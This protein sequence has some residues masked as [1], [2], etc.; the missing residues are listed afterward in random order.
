MPS[1]QPVQQSYTTLTQVNDRLQAIGLRT[2]PTT[3]EAAAKL[4]GPVSR[5]K[6][7]DLL[8]KAG[9]DAAARHW[10]SNRLIE[11]L[12]PES[13]GDIADD[14]LPQVGQ[15]MAPPGTAHAAAAPPAPAPPP[16][17]EPT[18]RP[19]GRGASVTPLH[20]RRPPG[21]ESDG[22]EGRADQPDGASREREYD[23]HV[24]YGAK[25]AVQF[26]CLPTK[27]DAQGKSKYLTVLV[28]AANARGASCKQG[29]DWEDSLMIN[30]E[31]HELGVILSVLMGYEGVA[32]FPGHGPQNDKIFDLSENTDPKWQGGFSIKLQ[33]GDRKF[34][35]PL[36]GTDFLQT[37]G[38]VERAAKSCLG[39]ASILTETKL[40]RLAQLRKLA[41]TRQRD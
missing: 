12:G 13:H 36:S 39:I 24:V 16:P 3:A 26:Q 30:M 7:V 33:Q 40:K 20:A 32:R 17:A 11:V 29:I 23:E 4:R 37:L 1:A 27:P 31:P 5:E 15:A 34:Y 22:S 21:S 35:V 9:Q 2:I 14:E 8:N 38:V 41:A 19:Q 10:V 18:S 28:K 6:F 25:Q